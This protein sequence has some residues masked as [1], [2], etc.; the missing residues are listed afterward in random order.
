[1]EA[2]AAASRPAVP[3]GPQVHRVLPRAF[4]LLAHQPLSLAGLTQAERDRIVITAVA[5]A[6]GTE[7]AVSVFGDSVWYFASEI[8]AVNRT[9]NSV[10]IQ[11]PADVPKHLVDDAKAALYCALRRGRDFGPWGASAVVSAGQAGVRTLRHVASLGMENFG[12]LRALHL[13]DHIADLS[14][15]IQAK[16]IANRLTIVDLVWYFHDEVLNPLTEHP[17]AGETVWAACGCAE[18]LDGPTGRTGKTSVIPLAI[19]RQLFAYCEDKLRTAD[20]VLRARDADEI[21]TRSVELTSVRDAVLYVLQVTSGMRNSETTGVTENCWRSEQKLGTTLHWVS[22]TEI[23]TGKGA[24]DFLVPAEAIRALEILQRYAEPLR[25]RL[26]DEARWLEGLLQAGARSDGKLVNGMSLAE[27][28]GRLNRVRLIQPCLFLTV[29]PTGSDHLGKG[30]QVEVMNVG[31]CSARLR[32]LARQAGTDWKLA[33][34]QCR[35]TFAFNVAN[36]R[37]GRM[38]LIFLKWQLK[39]SSISWTQLYASNP[40]QDHGLY[41]EMNEEL[42]QGRVSLMEGWMQLDTPL[43]GGAGKRVMQTRATGAKNLG[44]LLRY[45]A[46][47]ITL[48]ST[49]HAWCLTDTE[50]CKGQGVYEQ[51]MCSEC[52]AA[53]IDGEQLPAWQ[54]IHLDNLR[55]AAIDDCGPAVVQKAERS[56]QKSAKVLADLGVPLPT[57]DGTAALASYGGS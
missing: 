20:A 7:H 9:K 10:S 23:K 13:T 36:S 18:D 28:V 34:H 48:R 27:A 40:H 30:S 26:T 52:P 37:L 47:G 46:E 22:T 44:E 16:S 1:M 50:A 33:N 49:G 3:P 15:R 38:S 5:H 25:K 11:W 24:V 43:S 55:L 6:D 45:T 31:S 35:R 21:A 17:W 12:S 57:V 14:A 42:I 39:H 8:Q 32:L 29:A 19:Q 54:M 2:N 53:V 4:E 41:E 56:I 51:T